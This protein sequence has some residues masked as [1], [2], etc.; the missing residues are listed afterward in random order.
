M[1]N[2]DFEYTREYISDVQQALILAADEA[3]G[4]AEYLKAIEDTG[5]AQFKAL[6]RKIANQE[7]LHHKML[8]DFVDGKLDANPRSV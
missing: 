6:L 1:A 5:D 7:R 2:P 8:M 3:E 4:I